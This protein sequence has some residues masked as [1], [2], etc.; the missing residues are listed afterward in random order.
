MKYL[1][2]DLFYTLLILYQEPEIYTCPL[3]KGI[4][5]SKLWRG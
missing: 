2:K 4:S 5:D 3:K 1:G